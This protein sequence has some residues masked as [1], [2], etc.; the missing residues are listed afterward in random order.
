[1]MRPVLTATVAGGAVRFFPYPLNDG[2]PDLPWVVWADLLAL[3]NFSPSEREYFTQGLRAEW[4]EWSKTVA[5]ADG[6]LVLVPL[7]A[8]QSFLEAVVEE[9]GG[10]ALDEYMAGA[11]AAIREDA[12][13]LGTG[14]YAQRYL[15][16]ALVRWK[17]PKGGSE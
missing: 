16:A 1:M 2:R 14:E 11:V 7:F 4:P 12:A 6:L 17:T 10:T 8:G 9:F 5:T 13:H 15:A 3:F